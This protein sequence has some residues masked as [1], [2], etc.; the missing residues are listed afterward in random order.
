MKV[1][2]INVKLDDGLH[3]SYKKE[4]VFKPNMEGTA[5]IVTKDKSFL[6]RIF[7]QLIKLVKR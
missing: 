4:I 1:Y 2:L 7:E 3:T 6:E 5:D